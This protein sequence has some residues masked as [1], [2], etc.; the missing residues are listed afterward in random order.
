[1]PSFSA[2]VQVGTRKVALQDLPDANLARN[3]R[4]AAQQIAAGIS[5]VKCPKHNKTATQIR[6][7]FT[8]EGGVELAYESCC[9]EL[10]KAINKTLA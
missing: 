10:G 9:P 1:M 2:T 6:I 8:A 4:S 7:H 5:G 3:L